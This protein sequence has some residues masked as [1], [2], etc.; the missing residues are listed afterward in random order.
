[1]YRALTPAFII[2]TGLANQGSDNVCFGDSGGPAFVQI[3]DHEQ[4]V[5]L[6]VGVF[7]ASCEE[8]GSLYRLDTPQAWAFLSQYVNL[9]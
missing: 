1:L 6:S 9:P 5:A 2:F 7:S 8:G 4:L 3:N